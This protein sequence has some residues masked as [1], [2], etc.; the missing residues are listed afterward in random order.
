MSAWLSC[1]GGARVGVSAL[2]C[3]G[4]WAASSTSARAQADGL[5]LERVLASTEEHHPSVQAAV[6]NEAAAEAQIMAA[7]G[8]FD[9]TLSV[10]GALREGGYYSL[11]RLDAELRAPLPVLGAEVWAGYRIGQGVDANDRYPSY[12]SDRTLDRGEVRAGLRVPLLRDRALDDRRAGRQRAEL[13]RDGARE[14]RVLTVIELQK[15]AANAYWAWVAAGRVQQVC[16][17]RVPALLGDG[18][19]VACHFPGPLTPEEIAAAIA[20]AEAEPA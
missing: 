14:A 4:L 19:K 9:P 1:R 11:R 7:R 6:L 15:R 13:A 17:E 12:Y 2:L 5:S 18:H 3:V 10:Q 16:A 20:R 8:A